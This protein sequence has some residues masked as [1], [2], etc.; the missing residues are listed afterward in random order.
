[1]QQELSI[2]QEQKGSFIRIG[3]NIVNTI[4]DWVDEKFY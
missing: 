3:V 4:H 1:M 2:F